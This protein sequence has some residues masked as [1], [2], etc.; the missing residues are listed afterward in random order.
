MKVE[1]LT[2]HDQSNAEF[3]RRI[4]NRIRSFQNCGNSDQK[5]GKRLLVGIMNNNS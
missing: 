1:Q 4:S 3:C 2:S 5:I